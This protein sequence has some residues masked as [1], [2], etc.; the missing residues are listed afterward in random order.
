MTN[1]VTA[2]ELK[3]YAGRD[4]A[5]S[6]WFVID[7]RRIDQFASCTNDHQYIHVDIDRMKTSPWGDTIHGDPMSFTIT[8][9]EV[10]QS[11]ADCIEFVTSCPA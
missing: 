1:N 3:A 9:W 11:I 2:Q 7:Q 10:L 8:V 5:P 4:L 6:D